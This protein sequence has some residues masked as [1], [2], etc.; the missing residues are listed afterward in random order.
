PMHDFARLRPLQIERDALLVL[1]VGL[2][3]IVAAA[4]DGAASRNRGDAA[5]GVAALAL[6]DLDD[7]G[8]E[9]GEHLSRDRALLPDCPVDYANTVERSVHGVLYTTIGGDGVESVQSPARWA[10]GVTPAPSGRR[11][12]KKKK[13]VKC[14]SGISRT[15]IVRKKSWWVLV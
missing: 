13:D 7:L 1:I 5:A 3:V 10:A 14:R 15:L 11:G 2:E 4:L 9:G 8:A 12:G 6:F